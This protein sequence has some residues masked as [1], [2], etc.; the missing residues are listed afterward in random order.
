MLGTR[1][2]RRNNCLST[3]LIVLQVTS[4][5]TMPKTGMQRG[6]SE[7]CHKAARGGQAFQSGA[8]Q[9]KDEALG[10]RKSY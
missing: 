1:S 7:K 9:R 5:E 2:N 10:T 8:E 6:L 3:T 4:D